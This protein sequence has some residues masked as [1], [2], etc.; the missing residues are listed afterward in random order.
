AIGRTVQRGGRGVVVSSHSEHRFHVSGSVIVGYHNR[1]VDTG[2]R[3]LRI[4]SNQTPARPWLER[5]HRR[6]VL[7]GGVINNEHAVTVTV[8]DAP[9]RR[10]QGLNSIPPVTLKRGTRDAPVKLGPNMNIRVRQSL[11]DQIVDK[12]HTRR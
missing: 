4:G 3:S 12:R 5:P 2:P 11:T 7:G 6:V 9:N 10:G 1:V 8:D